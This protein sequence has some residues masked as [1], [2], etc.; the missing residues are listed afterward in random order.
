MRRLIIQNFSCI[1]NATIDF[2][3]VT[4]LIGPQASGKSVICKLNYFFLDVLHEQA[5]YLGISQSIE[6]YKD[7]IKSGS[8]I[9]F[10]QELGEQK[11]SASN[12]L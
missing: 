6:E 4:V 3:R 10:P 2:G 11:N 1:K 7:F 8:A 9:G 5:R 12:S